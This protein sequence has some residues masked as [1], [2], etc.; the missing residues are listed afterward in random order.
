VGIAAVVRPAYDRAVEA[1]AVT[2][3]A[4]TPRAWGV[5]RRAAGLVLLAAIATAFLAYMVVEVPLNE[6]TLSRGEATRFWAAALIAALIVV[7]GVVLVVSEVMRARR[8]APPP[9]AAAVQPRSRSPARP[10]IPRSLGFERIPGRVVALAAAYSALGLS[11]AFVLGVPLW[12]GGLA[13]ALPWVPLIAIEARWKYATYGIFA[14]FAL[15]VL[16]QVAHMGEHSMQVGQLLVHDGDLAVSHGVFGQLDF[17]LVHFVTDTALWIILGLLLIIYRGRNVWLWVAF[18]AASLHEV[19]HFYLF[20]MYQTHESYYAAGGFAGIM[21]ESGLIGSPLDRP[22]LHFTYN[23]I[24]VVP[25]ILALWDEA[26]RVDRGV[27]P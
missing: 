1:G 7:A 22:Y 2:G 8:A 10:L 4:L 12:I 3:R 27:R 9:A 23:L 5:S 19:E 26:R 21:G 25:M 20:W 24:V 14:A 15:L 13:F 11:I 16:L 17:E 18:A 6:A